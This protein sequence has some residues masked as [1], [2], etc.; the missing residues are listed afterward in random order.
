MDYPKA[1]SVAIA[2]ARYR[3][4]MGYDDAAHNSIVGRSM[5]YIG[6]W[7]A[8]VRLGKGS[9]KQAIF[10][11]FT[12]SEVNRIVCS[13]SYSTAV[14][15]GACADDPMRLEDSS[16]SKCRYC[17]FSFEIRKARAKGFRM[18]KGILSLSGVFSA[19][20]YR[21]LGPTS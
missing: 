19:T 7:A 10:V 20:L 4:S 6:E 16:T 15:K 5:G 3:E 12:R 13:H 18:R 9:W 14:S 17:Q 2:G 1:A 11:R 21:Q 8:T